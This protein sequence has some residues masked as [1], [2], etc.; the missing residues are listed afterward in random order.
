MRYFV[1][2]LIMNLLL[3]FLLFVLPPF[4]I[5]QWVKCFYS[6]FPTVLLI[7]CTPSF[8]LDAFQYLWLNHIV[9]GLH[10][11]FVPQNFNF[12]ACLGILFCFVNMQYTFY[13]TTT[14][15]WNL[16]PQVVFCMDRIL[17]QV[18][19]TRF[20]LKKAECLAL[21]G[22]YQEAQEIAK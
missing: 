2:F 19:C 1:L 4:Y 9:L 5:G 7:S 3:I 18:P 11:Q 8:L 21:L 15:Y 20:K 12:K 16:C 22:R 6:L 14:W 13:C 10:M 17:E